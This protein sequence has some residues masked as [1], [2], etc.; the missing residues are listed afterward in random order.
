MRL[1][2]I[3]GRSLVAVI[4]FG[5]LTVGSLSLFTEARAFGGCICPQIYAPVKCSNGKTY[6]NGCYASCAHATGC[7]PVGPGP[8]L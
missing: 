6:T 2:R 4:V 8:V 1:A 7:V 5:A 3:L